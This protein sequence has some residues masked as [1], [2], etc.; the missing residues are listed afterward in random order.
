[1]SAT[2]PVPLG[3]DWIFLPTAHDGKNTV[4]FYVNG[5]LNSK[6]NAPAA[7]ANNS[8]LLVGQD[9]VGNFGAGALTSLRYSIKH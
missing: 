7:K 3:K 1:M 2:T 9:G 8:P 4:S 6:Q 5:D